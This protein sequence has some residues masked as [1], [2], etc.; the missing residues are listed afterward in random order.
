MWSCT[1]F[2]TPKGLILSDIWARRFRPASA[3]YPAH[4]SQKINNQ[5]KAQSLEKDSPHCGIVRIVSTWQIAC[6][7]LVTIPE[8][9]LGL[10]DDSQGTNFFQRCRCGWHRCGSC[11]PAIDRWVVTNSSDKNPT[12]LPG[13]HI[14]HFKG[15]VVVCCL[16]NRMRE[17]KQYVWQRIKLQRMKDA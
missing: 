12:S 17:Q 1:Q 3:R 9:L 8:T 11:C 14:F 15:I 2:Y 4:F 13:W 7:F 5:G 6:V 16:A 10:S